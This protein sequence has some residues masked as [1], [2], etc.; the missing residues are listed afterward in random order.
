MKA[1]IL[2]TGEKKE[3]FLVQ[4]ISSCLKQNYYNY[5]II[6]LFS[7]LKNLNLLK[8]KF[9]KQIVFKK[10]LIKKRNPVKDQLF[11]I[12]E[13]IKLATGQFIF[14][15]DGDDQFKKN[16]LKLI[17]NSRK[18]NMLNLDDHI[19][20]KKNKL[21]YINHNKIKDNF[22]YKFFLNPWPDKVCTSCI[23]GEKKLFVNFFRNININKYQ[24][25][26]IDILILIFYLDKIYKIKKKLTIKNVLEKS[27]DTNYSD[28]LKSI[29]WKRRIEQ[30]KY[31]K[32]V[33]SINYSLEFY[34]SKFIYNLFYFQKYIRRIF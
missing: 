23:S 31:L 27:V 7:N 20:L 1:T 2:I 8:R 10:I 16:K 22:F 15:L 12:S 24:Y 17:I 25:L 19:L 21:S 30:H 26:A 33:Q 11:K 13:G 34:F 5:E 28:Y 4:T 14:L 9:N 29:Y 6:L 3:N 18:K 32:E